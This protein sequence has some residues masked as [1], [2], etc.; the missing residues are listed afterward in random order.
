M[1][2]VERP[3]KVYTTLDAYQAGFLALKGHVVE[4]IEQGDKIVF[5]FVSN[6]KLFKDLSDYS[7]G[8]IVEASK[9]AFAIK[10]LKSQIHSLRRS[11]NELSKARHCN[12]P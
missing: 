8:A 1:K 12:C 3:G 6:D 9:L 10:T 7:N 11:K 4:F 2:K 5:S